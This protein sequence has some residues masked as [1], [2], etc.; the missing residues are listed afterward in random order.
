MSGLGRE[1]VLEPSHLVERHINDVGTS[2]MLYLQQF[3]YVWG[4]HLR[5]RDLAD[6]LSRLGVT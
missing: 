5:G 3:S 4:G 1:M 2:K 6:K